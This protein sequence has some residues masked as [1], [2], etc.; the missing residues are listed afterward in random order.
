[1]NRRCGYIEYAGG[2][3]VEPRMSHDLRDGYP[4]SNVDYKHPGQ[5]IFRQRVY[6]FWYFVLASPN[7]GEQRLHVFVVERESSCEESKEDD[8]TTPNICGPACVLDSADDFWAGIVRA[9]AACF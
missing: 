7:L 2:Q 5:Q 4:P 1:M 9:S 6:V 8:A 3:L